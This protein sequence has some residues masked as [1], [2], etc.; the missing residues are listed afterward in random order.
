MDIFTSHND[1]TIAKPIMRTHLPLNSVPR[2]NAP[3]AIKK[4]PHINSIGTANV[5]KS[6]V[7][8]KPLGNA[9]K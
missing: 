4:A 9:G 6:Y 3:I 1:N 7:F 5:I 8:T 2:I